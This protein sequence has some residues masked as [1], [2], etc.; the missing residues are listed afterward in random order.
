MLDS[1]SSLVGQLAHLIAICLA[2]YAIL[3][4]VHGI[5][6]GGMASII[7]AVLVGFAAAILMKL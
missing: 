5:E 2:I 3:T 1:L 6:R 4:A 7:K